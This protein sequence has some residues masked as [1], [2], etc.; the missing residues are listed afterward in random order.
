[1]DFSAREQYRRVREKVDAVEPYSESTSGRWIE[2]LVSAGDFT[3]GREIVLISNRNLPSDPE[4]RV[5]ADKQ[6]G[7]QK[8]TECIATLDW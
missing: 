3:N 1:V 7:F 4:S 6:G 8:R 5:V 2:S